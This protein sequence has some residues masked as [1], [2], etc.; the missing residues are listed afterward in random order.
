MFVV[1]CAGFPVPVSRYWGSFDAVEISETRLGVPGS[2]TLRRWVREAGADYVF[3]MLAPAPV[4][5]SNFE[6][7]NDNHALLQGLIPVGEQL[8]A[9]ALVFRGEESFKHSKVNRGSLAAFVGALPEGLPTPA[10]ELPRWNATQIED[11]VGNAAIAVRN[12]LTD[13]P[14]PG[15]SL[16]YYRLPGPA[17]RRSRY[18]ESMMNEVFDACVNSGAEDTICIFANADMQV[19]ATA[20]RERLAALKS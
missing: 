9:R 17:G 1:G 18:D 2:G 14:A 6:I 19:N 5:D 11:A 12:P 10:F 15:G 16:G 8:G 4:T 20:L 7:S 13:G 3:T